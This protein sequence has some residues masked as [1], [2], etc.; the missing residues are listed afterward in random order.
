MDEEVESAGHAPGGEWFER[1]WWDDRYSAAADAPVFSGHVNAQL[2]REAASLTPGR[3]LD[4]GAGEGGDALWL[5]SRGWEV[6]GLDFSPV[7][8]RRA[9]DQAAA[10]GVGHRTTWHQADVRTWEPGEQRWD[11][12]TSHFLHLPDGGMRDVVRRLAS[13]VAPGGTLLVVG[14]HP[15]DL[16]TGLRH[17]RP[18]WLFTPEDL[19]PALDPE[20]FEV[21][22]AEVRSRTESHHHQPGVTV[23]DS[24]VRA[25]RRS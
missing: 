4:V 21:E 2:A 14:H 1:D 20:Q 17:G 19:L 15:D 25:R 16:A 8:L 11:L 7:A 23:R 22:V 12:V 5:A 10:E 13:A 18:E 9:A 24:V 6:T 3:A